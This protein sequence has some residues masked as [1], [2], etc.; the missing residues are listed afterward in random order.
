MAEKPK[1]KAIIN[2]FIENDSMVSELNTLQ[3]KA[4]R[5]QNYLVNKVE[6]KNAEINSAYTIY[7]WSAMGI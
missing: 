5:D 3:K 6:I 4:S 2:F 1:N 7:R